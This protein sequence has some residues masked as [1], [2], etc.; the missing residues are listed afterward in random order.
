[1]KITNLSESIDGGVIIS[2]VDPLS[3]AA[4]SRLTVGQ[5]ILE[6]NRQPI[7]TLDDFQRVTRKL[8]DGSALVLRVTYPQ[9]RNLRLIA[10]RI[11]E[12]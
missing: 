1:M 3:P 10:I 12:L 2:E 11:G 8:K 7:R 9:Q 6:A 4:D 5:I